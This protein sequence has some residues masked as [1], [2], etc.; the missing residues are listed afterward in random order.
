MGRPLLSAARRASARVS[1]PPVEPPSTRQLFRDGSQAFDE[2]AA[3]NVV[4]SEEGA[5]GLG[6]R[7][8]D[9]VDEPD[10]ILHPKSSR[11]VARV[12][13][14]AES[15]TLNFEN[16]SRL[17]QIANDARA[18]DPADA[19]IA[20][21]VVKEID[22]YMANLSARQVMSGDFEMANQLV[23]KA[24]DLWARG[25]R[26]EVI[27]EAFRKAE[28]DAGDTGG[29]GFEN[30]LRIRFRQIARNEKQFRQFTPEEQA[31]I[32]RVAQGGAI[33]N[34]LR[35][36][37]KMAPTGIV[38][39]ALSG[40]LSAGIFGPFMGPYGGLV[41]PGLGLVGRDLATRRTLQ[42]ASRAS[43]IIRQPTR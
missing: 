25:R 27:D 22:E 3:Q 19:R 7:I 23:T 20:G 10:P 15:G 30:K 2:A 38:S 17:R 12:L 32:T 18:G 29:A 36:I 34:T 39:G 28:L 11:V 35:N 16:I 14:D 13:E 6:T 21:Q 42:N 5:L 40:G 43:E 33:D 26:S 37:G 41:L 9:R 31:A 1:A 4:L 24:R 8:L